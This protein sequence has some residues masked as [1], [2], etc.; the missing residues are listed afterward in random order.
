MLYEKLDKKKKDRMTQTEQLGQ[1]MVDAG[2]DFGP[3]T[4]YGKP[5]CI[6]I[7]V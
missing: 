7:V 6:I 5:F 2:N 3:G 1:Y 4:S